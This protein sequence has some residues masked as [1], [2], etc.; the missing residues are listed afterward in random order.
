ME[1]K[2]E[3]LY[4]VRFLDMYALT[5][6]ANHAYKKNILAGKVDPSDMVFAK[7]DHYA[8]I[9]SEIKN[10]DIFKSGIRQFEYN[11]NDMEDTTLVLFLN[12]NGRVNKIDVTEYN[13]HYGP[14]GNSSETAQWIVDQP[15]IKKDII[16]P[17]NETLSGIEILSALEN[18]VSKKYPSKT[19]Q[20]TVPN[21]MDLMLN[22][23]FN[24][25]E[26]ENNIPPIYEE[27]KMLYL[28]D[29]TNTLIKFKFSKQIYDEDPKEKLE[30][31]DVTEFNKTYGKDAARQIIDNYASATKTGLEK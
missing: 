11:L 4:L 8:D 9:L 2:R 21:D 26:N 7:V 25:Y 17:S 13:K 18:F 6:L 29:P 23:L 27:E 30:E 1:K 10:S 16:T 14:K 22:E 24:Q 5:D 15:G 31:I 19:Y 28:C 12:D 3:Y 20:P